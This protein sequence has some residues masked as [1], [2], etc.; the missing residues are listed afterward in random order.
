MYITHIAIWTDNLEEMRAFYVKYFNGKANN[1]Y[2][3]A[4]KGFESY[5]ISF[6]S[7]PSLELMH[8]PGLNTGL[9]G[10]Y[11]GFTHIAFK[12]GSET[13]VDDMT[14]K[15]EAEGVRIAGHPRRTGD[16]FYESVILDTDGNKI[17]LVA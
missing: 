2:T 13:M 6:P 7:G 15:F 1:K 8:K 3:N 14:A 17:E 5:F 12:L 16:G 4:A 11:F 10:D 9:C